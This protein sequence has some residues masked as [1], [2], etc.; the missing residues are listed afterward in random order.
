M[1]FLNDIQTEVRE[2]GIDRAVTERDTPRVFNWLLTTFSYQGVSDQ[3]ART[4]ILQNGSASWSDI[5]AGLQTTPSCPRLRSYWHYDACRYDKGSFSCSDPEHIDS[6]PVPL[7][8]LRNGRLNQTAYSFFLFV[9]DIADG[10][11]IG[12]IDE[13]LVAPADP[14]PELLIGPLRNVYGVSDKILSMTLSSLLLGASKGRPQWFETGTAMVA[15]D[16]LV[17]NFLHRSGI[18]ERSGSA[19]AYGVGCYTAGGCADIVR[20]AAERI[21]ASKFNPTFPKIF[22]RF[23][24]HAIWRY[25]AADG[26]DLCNGNRIDDR[27]SCQINYCHLF[28]DC[29]RKQLKSV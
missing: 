22:P 20:S 21:D 23:V 4:Y 24:Q 17:H 11:L 25:C 3:A 15:I 18:L 9:R 19:H 5:E 2:A 16:S 10:D 1:T 27:K 26:I 28:Q 13:Q 7:P 29:S 8:R 14:Y 6:C 12:W